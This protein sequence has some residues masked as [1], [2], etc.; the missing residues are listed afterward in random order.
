[1]RAPSYERDAL[2]PIA[3]ETKQHRPTSRIVGRVEVSG[4]HEMGHDGGPL[5]IIMPLHRRQMESFTS[6]LSSSPKFL[7]E[8]RY[9]FVKFISKGKNISPWIS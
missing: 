6:E 4:L 8:I 2:Q 5:E 3:A 7:G 9:M 1:M